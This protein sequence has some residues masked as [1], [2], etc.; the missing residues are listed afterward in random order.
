MPGAGGFDS[1]NCIIKGPY[2]LTLLQVTNLMQDDIHFV[3]CF[4]P[5]SWIRKLSKIKSKLM[6]LCFNLLPK[7][8]PQGPPKHSE[9]KG[10][11]R[12]LLST[13]QRYHLTKEFPNFPL[14]SSWKH[15]LQQLLKSMVQNLGLHLLVGTA[16]L[17]DW[18]TE[19][20]TQLRTWFKAG[21]CHPCPL[22]PHL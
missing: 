3:Q 21:A 6:K 22:M 15:L 20:S 9:C 18:A 8:T 19:R 10:W 13:G 11:E 5:P 12:N 2:M 7:K 14:A 4:C 17:K 1:I 16:L